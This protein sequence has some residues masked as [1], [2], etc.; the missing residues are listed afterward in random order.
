MI[1]KSIRWWAVG[2][3]I[4]YG[5]GFAS[6]WCLVGVL[7][8]YV[9]LYQEPNCFDL[10]M[11]ADETGID[12]GGACVRICSAEVLP[13]QVIWVK[14]FEVT[15]GQYNTVAYVENQNQTAA[16]P[17]LEYTFELYNKGEL[18]A[19]R[20]GTTVLPPNSVYPIFEGRVLTDG[21]ESVTETKITIKPVELWLPASIGRGQFRSTDI[22]LSNA[23]VRPRLDVSIENT[24]LTAAEDVEVVATVFSENGNPV[25][26]SQ[27]FI[28]EIDG[29]STKDIVFTWPNSVAKTVKSC[30]IPTDIAVAIDL[31]GSM[32]NDGGNPPQPVTAALEAAG[33]FVKAL[34][35]NDQVAVVTFATQAI[36]ATELTV[37]NDAVA[38]AILELSIDKVEETGYTNTVEALKL[39]QAELNSERHNPD[40]RRVLVLLTDGLPTISG[41]E[42]VVGRAVAEALALSNDN[43][44]IYAI[45]LGEQAD[46]QFVN[47]IASDVSNAY[48]APSGAD[49]ASIYAEITTSICEV[50]PTKIDVIAK[51]KTNFAPLR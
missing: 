38:N 16:T 17:E 44:E 12:C 32:N 30:V 45:G 8:Y 25:T 48:F 51:T 3:R 22:N 47:S 43:I 41:D 42:D 23:D 36:V 7:V 6:F 29:R 5:L 26:A 19:K 9:N 10:V 33:Q 20:S 4:Q 46:K 24:E 1:K 35:E 31:S 13:P 37:L 15:K 40:A 11:N 14:S 39:A 34:N 21:R 49:L 27:T 28:E 2:R 50:G 18:V